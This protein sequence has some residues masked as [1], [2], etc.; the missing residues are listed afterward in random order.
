MT[1]HT[2]SVHPWDTVPLPFQRLSLDG[3]I[4]EVNSRWQEMTGYELDECIGR[5]Y[6]DLMPP[7][8][9]DDFHRI[10]GEL[11]ETGNLD[12]ADCFLQRKDGQPLNV[13]IFGTL[14]R[15]TREAECL[16]V[17]I[18]GFRKTETDLTESE[19]RFRS[20][21]ELAPTP[22]LIH[23]GATIA[24]ANQSAARFLGYDAPGELAGLSLAGIIHPEDRAMVAHRV[25]RVITE[26]VTVAPQ[27][28]RLV[29]KDGSIAVG[30]AVSSPVVL[31][32]KRA[33]HTML[34]DLSERIEAERALAESEGR[35][36]TLFEYSGDAIV[37]HDGHHVR[38][39]NRSALASFGLP[40]GID[41]STLELRDYVHSDSLSDVRRRIASLRSGE[42]H[43]ET[44]EYRLLRADRTDWFA[45]AFSSA[46]ELQG[47]TLIQTILRDLTDR[48]RSESE[49]ASYRTRLEQLLAERT[50]SLERVRQELN[51]VTTVVSR[52]V[53]MRDPYTAGHQRRVAAFALE[54]AAKLNMDEADIEYLGVAASLHDVGK[55]GVPAE[56]L[57]KPSMLTGLEFELVKTHVEAGYSIVRS[58]ELPGPVAEIVYQHHE[59]LDGS[60]YP[61]GLSGDELLLGSRVL[62]V[63]DVVEAMCSHRPYRPSVGLAAALAEI[64]KGAGTL[65]DADVVAACR[66]VVHD[67]FTFTG[68]F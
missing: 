11:M 49:L 57:A 18:T 19:A 63:A 56:I 2:T 33:V 40:E 50:E 24:M 62:M 16:L 67:G 45:E 38:F 36:R 13:R 44:S 68:D 32:G 35:Y 25:G 65:Y 10:L 46:L 6:T 22:I 66:A 23:D 64:A 59:R 21:F 9:I 26:D 4:V 41:V 53:E 61:R 28:E 31:E 39:A 27:K 55:V 3:C 8:H 47:E 51:A 29:R 7:G 37:V 34:L 48:R 60:G 43:D 15:E 52:T 17:D 54:V 5:V 12:G 1:R 42:Q 58:A 30:E 14:N 20:L